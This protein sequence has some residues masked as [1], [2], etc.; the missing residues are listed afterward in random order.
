[1]GQSRRVGG[2]PRPIGA[3]RIVRLRGR[4]AAGGAWSAAAA[5]SPASPQSQRLGA[6][7]GAVTRCFC[8]PPYLS[9][10]YRSA[11]RG[12]SIHAVTL[13]LVPARC[14][15]GG[16]LLRE[17]RGAGFCRTEPQTRPRSVDLERSMGP[18]RDSYGVPAS[19]RP[20]GSGGGSGHIAPLSFLRICG[21]RHRTRSSTPPSSLAGILP[22][23]GPPARRRR[24]SSRLSF[25]GHPSP[26]RP[27]FPSTTPPPPAAT[28][29]LLIIIA[30][31]PAPYVP[32]I[33]FAPLPPFDLPFLPGHKQPPTT[34]AAAAVHP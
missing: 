24:P 7:E 21:S 22:G 28:H 29:S 31:H 14:L 6:P 12:S 13:V 32:L 8:R 16:A 10:A 30:V 19:W 5:P 26:A 4:R 1:M 15:P 3:A 34:T 18:A 17:C 25:S 2:V 20:M 33:P 11:V 23:L 9:E 27:L